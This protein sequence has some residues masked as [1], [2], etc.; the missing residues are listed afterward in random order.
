M[1]YQ[2]RHRCLG[3]F[4]GVE[5]VQGSVAVCYHPAADNP[6]MGF[7]EIQSESEA[8]ALVD[9]IASI[10]ALET[11]KADLTVEPFNKD[12]SD[13]VQRIGMH[14]LLLN[15]WVRRLGIQDA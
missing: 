15:F 3:V 5:W 7:C 14:R 10:P 4:Q 2:V 1:T 13:L 11:L 6:E 12:G 8:L 9:W